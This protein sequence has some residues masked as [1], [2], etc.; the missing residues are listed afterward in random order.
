MNAFR[1][2]DAD[3]TYV[4]E[5]PFKPLHLSEVNFRAGNIRN[6]HSGEHVYPSDIYLE[7]NVFGSGRIAVD[8]SAN[9]L[10]KPHPGIKADLTLKNVELDYFKPIIRRYHVSVR[11]GILS[12]DGKFEYAPKTKV[13][14]LKHITVQSVHVDYIHQSK[15]EAA[16]REVAKDVA[17]TAK[18]L[19]NS[20]EVLL[21][22]D[23]I[24]I[25][26]STFA[27]MNKAVK[28][29]YRI[30]LADSDLRLD[31][32]S[33]RGAEGAAVGIVKGKFMASGNTTANVTFQ[34]KAK[35]PDFDLKIRIDDTKLPAMNDLL[36][37]YGNFD[38]V[39]GLFS[40][41]SELSVRNGEVNGYIKPLF[42]DMDV[43]DARQERGKSF[44]SKIREGVVAALAWVL[45]NRTR[46]EVGTQ[47][48]ISGKLDSPQYSTWEA[49][50][51]LLKNAFI[52]AISPGFE[53]KAPSN[54][55][56]QNN[57]KDGSL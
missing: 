8:G 50:F 37:A 54:N 48:T 3:I 57:N 17:R 15:T 10:A 7:G 22:V 16:E 19:N 52:K 21:R 13:V 45:E 12:T 2:R 32:L 55:K 56:A 36:M 49:V 53:K 42:K 40:F 5:S 31:N 39:G 23:K 4:D 38:V 18:K 9:F 41:Y 25:L 20:P 26:K 24:N 46:G 43:Y 30:F 29:E 27:F 6:V 14:D 47:V 11:E 34:P 51:G 44:F 35:S 28:P 1:V 33:N